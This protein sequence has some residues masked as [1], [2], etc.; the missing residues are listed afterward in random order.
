MN[1]TENLLFSSCPDPALFADPGLLEDSGFFFCYDGNKTCSFQMGGNGMYLD[2]IVHFI[3]KGPDIVV[4][5]WKQMNLHTVVGGSHEQ[6]GTYNAL[7]YT[8]D[9]YIEFLAVEDEEILGKSDHPLIL[10]LK[11]D[12]PESSG[13][14][15]ICIRTNDMEHLKRELEH[16]GIK[17]TPIFNAQ[18][19]TK[20]GTIRKW[21]MLFID[22]EVGQALPYPFFI[23]WEEPDSERYEALQKDGTIQESNQSLTI[24]VCVFDVADPRSTAL[25][26]SNV[27]GIN[28]SGAEGNELPLPNSKLIFRVGEGKERL[29]KVFL[30]GH[31]EK[32]HLDYAGGSYVIG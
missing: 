8:K 28:P 16:K 32:L 15:T 14:G 12:L 19:R 6:W 10:H 13:F 22:E 23:E 29:G 5:D 30:T 18:R 31:S 21:K 7:L 27:L 11:H 9:S 17:T 24:D 26:W 4:R 2:H 1:I 25:R 20:G 3:N